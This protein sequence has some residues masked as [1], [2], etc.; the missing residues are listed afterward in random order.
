MWPN[1]CMKKTVPNSS[2][3]FLAK[4]ITQF[5]KRDVTVLAIVPV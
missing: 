4:C 3:D 5:T 2:K 1:N